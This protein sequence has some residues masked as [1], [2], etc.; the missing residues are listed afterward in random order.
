MMTAVAV[1]VYGRVQGVGFRWSTARKARALDLVGWVQ[2]RRDGSVE[3][4]CIGRRHDIDVM[5]LWLAKGPSAARVDRLDVVDATP[6]PELTDFEI[7]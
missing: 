7:R 3:L 1:R 5:Q 2:N 6:D 4:V